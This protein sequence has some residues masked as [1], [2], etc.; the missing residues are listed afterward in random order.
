MEARCPPTPSFP[1]SEYD[2]VALPLPLPPDDDMAMRTFTFGS[3]Q[4]STIKK[5]HVVRGA[6]GGP[7]ARPHGRARA[8]AG[9]DVSTGGL[10][11]LQKTVR[12]GPAGRLLRQRVSACGGAD[13]RR[14]AAGR[15][16]GGRG[17]AGAG[18]EGHGD[19]RVRAVDAR[20][21]GASRAAVRDADEPVPRFGQPARWV[22][23][24]GLRVGRAG[25]RRPRCSL[26]ATSSPSGMSVA[27]TPWPWGSFCQ[28]RPWTGSR[29]RFRCC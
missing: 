24:A 7:L 20:P 16:S 23:P 10:S 8:T 19:R 22:P 5:G 11:Q 25:V 12:P 3:A 29:R 9:R 26:R 18:G 17:G 15:L 1:H 13:H 28:S 27:R 14:R 21:P 2:A 4:V 6:H